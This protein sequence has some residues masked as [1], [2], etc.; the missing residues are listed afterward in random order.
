MDTKLSASEFRNDGAVGVVLDGVPLVTAK[1]AEVG[2]FLAVALKATCR[3]PP[4]P[5]G[6]KHGRKDPGRDLRL[7]SLKHLGGALCPDPAEEGQG[8]AGETVGA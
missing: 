1:A 8:P 3:E 2:A 5:Q 6:T 7:E 4:V